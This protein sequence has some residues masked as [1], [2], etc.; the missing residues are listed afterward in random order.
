M[1]YVALQFLAELNVILRLHPLCHDLDIQVA[2]DLHDRP[3]QRTLFLV[4]DRRYYDGTIN[5]QSVW[6]KLKKTSN[7]RVTGSEVVDLDL[8]SQLPQLCKILIGHGLD[9][10]EGDCFEQLK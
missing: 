9:V 1:E 8:R 7:R 4:L 3:D 2:T 6:R 10:I 5:L